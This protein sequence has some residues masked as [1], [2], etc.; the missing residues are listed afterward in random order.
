MTSKKDTNA[1]ETRDLDSVPVALQSV[2]AAN[3]AVVVVG[4]VSAAAAAGAGAVLVD[5]VVA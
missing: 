5:D 2:V 1:S 3:A 4:A